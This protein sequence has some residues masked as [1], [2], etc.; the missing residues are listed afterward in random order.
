M[1]VSLTDYKK[2]PVRTRQFILT[3]IQA[4]ALS[5]IIKS[6]ATF[7]LLFGGSRSGKTAFLIFLIFYL[8][9]KYPNSRHL[10]ARFRFN[11]AKTSLWYDTIPKVTRL[12]GM[13]GELH[14]NKADWF[15][16]LPNG[17]EVW[18]AGLDD[19]ERLEKVLGN[20]YA[21]IYINEASQTSYLALTTLMSRL[22]QR[23]EGFRNR[24]FIDCNPPTKRHWIYNLFILKRDPES[25]VPLKRPDNYISMLLNPED[26]LENIS[27][28]YLD[29]LEDM[30]E[31]QRK[32]F[33]LGQFLDDVEG[34]L[35][36][37]EDIDRNR[38]SFARDLIRTAV[39]IDPATT[40]KDSSD[41]TGIVVGGVDG[42]M[43]KDGKP[44]PHGY[45]LDDRSGTYTPDEWADL[46][47][48]LYYEYDCDCI[49]AE[50]NQG[51]DMVRHIIET[52]D[53]NIKVYTVH[54]TKGKLVRAEPV[55]AIN[56][57]GRLH[58]VGQFVD[59]EEQM[60]TF[61]GKTGEPS[62][63]N[64]DAM[65]WL[66]THLMIGSKTEDTSGP[67]TSGGSNNLPT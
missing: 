32:R 27:N 29:I 46:A 59:L 47:I 64:F 44:R 54:A 31:R 8:A 10:V 9:D 6:T 66:I 15:V 25:R 16:R 34:A 5:L 30:P 4:K 37:Q 12:M 1:E 26:N 67:A 3:F 24:F 52:K 61:T 48:A 13:K 28:E 41:K 20:E 42:R 2:S 51:G 43:T 21:T 7:V 38:E 49:V 45:I 17:S 35:F 53:P 65:V 18:I 55:S 40:S 62:P 63:D 23:I 14:F 50:V 22:A 19:K 33:K 57:Q 11:H 58:M 36:K 56:E 39:S 60:T